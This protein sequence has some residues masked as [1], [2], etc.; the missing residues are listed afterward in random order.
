MHKHHIH[1]RHLGGTNDPDN[2]VEV[3]V[4]EHARIHHSQWIL[5]GRWQDEVA[6]RTL[7]GQI[8]RDEA[9]KLAVSRALKGKPSHRRGKSLS[10]Q[11]KQNLR[12][13]RWPEDRKQ[14]FSAY[15]KEIRAQP[16]GFT[17]AGKSHTDESNKKNSASH[18]GRPANKTSFQ[19]GHIPWNRPKS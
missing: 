13:I 7:S 4:E 8:T 2:L 10:E 15:C 19:K 9:R 16:K 6:W 12:G 5:G 3:S 11:H 1:P 18:I 14:K 17:F